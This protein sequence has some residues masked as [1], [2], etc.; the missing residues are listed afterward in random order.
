MGH[1]GNGLDIRDVVAR[2]ADAL[3]VHGLCAVV[4]GRRNGGGVVAVDKLGLDAEAR[5][6]DL[7]LVVRAAVQVGRRHDI[8]AGVGERRKSD[9]LR[10][11]AG[12]GRQ[13]RHAALE[14]RD[15]LLEDVD[16]GLSAPRVLAGRGRL[17]QLWLMGREVRYARS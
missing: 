4:D 9:E 7:E 14:G 2:V 5:Q 17:V 16:G 13:R 11:L 1:L 6:E 12:R 10:A 15:A 8:V 3:D